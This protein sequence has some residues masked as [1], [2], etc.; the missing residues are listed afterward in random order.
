[1][2]EEAQARFRFPGGA[3]DESAGVQASGAGDATAAVLVFF[4]AVEM[5]SPADW[6][7][8]HMFDHGPEQHRVSGIR[9]GQRWVSTPACRAARLVAAEP[10]DRAD[11]VV[12]YLFAEPVTQATRVFS[13]LGTALREQKRYIRVKM[14]ILVSAGY[15]VT[16]RQASPNG[17]LGAAVLP[18]YPSRGVYLTVETSGPDEAARVEALERLVAVEGVAG[19]WRYAPASRDLSPMKSYP[20]QTVTVFY[21]YDDPVATAGR[22]NP[23]LEREWAAA[24]VEGLFAAPFYVPQP[25]EIDQLVG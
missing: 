24:G 17:A 11:Y 9:N 12:Q 6:L 13:E 5:G 21:L 25:F 8:W 15:D 19:A 18:W 22:L 20:G 16:H 23:V 2:S 14:P 7:R 1:M 3:S 10:F 4:G